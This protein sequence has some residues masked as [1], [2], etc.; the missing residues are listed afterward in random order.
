VLQELGGW[1]SPEMVQRYAHRSTDHLS[2]YVNRRSALRL[3]AVSGDNPVT[4]NKNA[5]ELVA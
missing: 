5:T 2:D 1:E 3:T 4:G